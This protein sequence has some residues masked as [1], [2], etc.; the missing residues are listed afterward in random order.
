MAADEMQVHL[1]AKDDLT[2]E[3]KN[4]TKQIAR[5]EAQIKDLGDGT[6]PETERDIRRLTQQLERAQ[7]RAKIASGAVSKLD[8]DLDQ[9]GYSAKRAGDKVSGANREI[10][11]GDSSMMAFSKSV[12][13]GALAATAAAAAAVGMGLAI[14]RAAELTWM[15]A[16]Q[17]ALYEK[18]VRRTD[19]VFGKHAKRVRA[20]ADESNELWG[21]SVEDVAAMAAGIGDILK[22]LGFTTKQATKLTLSVGD[23]IPA[24]AEWNTVGMDAEQVSHALTAAMTGEREMLKSLGIVIMEEDVKAKVKA[25]EAAGKF[26]DETEKQ[27]KAIATLKLATSGSADALRSYEGNT[28]S[29][30]RTMNRVRAAVADLRDSGLE[31]LAVTI[32]DLAA[33][34]RGD[35]KGSGS[36]VQDQLDWIMNNR[37]DIEKTFLSVA[38]YTLKF[39]SASARLGQVTSIAYGNIIIQL[40]SI[41]KILGFIGK[42][43]QVKQFGD[44]MVQAGVDAVAAGEGLGDVATTLDS[45]GTNALNAAAGLDK[46]KTSWQALKDSGAP[47]NVI[48]ASRNTPIGGDTSVGMGVGSLGAAGLA[49]YHG[50]YSSAL[51]G[52]SILSGVRGTN[53]GSVH[54]DHRYGRAMDIRGPRLGAYAQVVRRNGGYAAMHGTGGNRHLHVVPQTRRPAPHAVGGN[55]FH[56]DVTVVNP[57]GE[58]D[59]QGAVARGLRAAARQTKER[60]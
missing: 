4:A 39:A 47:K 45:M 42:S 16:Q 14:K 48:D 50:A 35:G 43:D 46:V 49:A 40:G 31:I 32:R 29:V 23:L 41:V 25:M 3:L 56:A 2:K 24:L 28:D 19:I 44:S 30:G 38:G 59:I 52:H 8:D 36:L 58:M 34:L 33:A 21:S 12:K 53:L 57:S 27:K 51:G 6:S 17:A 60:G 22:P 37:K 1:I 55:T 10:D 11:K 13:K 26:T 7:D 18:K 54:S 5:L 15:A 9:M 20:W